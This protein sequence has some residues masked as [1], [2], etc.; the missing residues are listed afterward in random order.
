MLGYWIAKSESNTLVRIDPAPIWATIQAS[1]TLQTPALQQTIRFSIRSPKTC[2]MLH[3]PVEIWTELVNVSDETVTVMKAIHIFTGGA[4]YGLGPQVNGKPNK[5]LPQ[6]FGRGENSDD[7]VVL[8]PGE[9]SITRIP[10]FLD[11]ISDL[12]GKP[13]E[14]GTGQYDLALQYENWIPNVLDEYVFMYNRFDF[15]V[16]ADRPVWTG[17]LQSNTITVVIVDDA[18]N[19]EKTTSS[20]QIFSPEPTLSG[21]R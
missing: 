6:V 20:T 7:Y 8:L 3:E 9:G 1:P 5:A 18:A 10:D 2:Y 13:R 12:D 17:L 14:S 19:C 21:F 11:L 4:L 16:F 15:Q